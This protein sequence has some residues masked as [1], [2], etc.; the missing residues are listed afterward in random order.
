MNVYMGAYREGDFTYS[1]ESF[2]VSNNTNESS[3]DYKNTRIL[4]EIHES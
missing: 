4:D 3:T 2:N 1:S